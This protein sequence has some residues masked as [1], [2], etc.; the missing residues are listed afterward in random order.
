MKGTWS[1]AA[2]G[3]KFNLGYQTVTFLQFLVIHSVLK[4][5]TQELKSDG[6][7]HDGESKKKKTPKKAAIETTA[8][9]AM[10]I[11]QEINKIIFSSSVPGICFFQRREER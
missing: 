2:G 8:K 6:V 9:L 5:S 7:E 11:C 3:R 1:I 4:S 10:E